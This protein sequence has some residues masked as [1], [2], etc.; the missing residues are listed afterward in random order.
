VAQL[1]TLGGMNTTAMNDSR[2]RILRILFVIFET[3]FVGSYI[4]IWR[5]GWHSEMTPSV[6]VLA[7]GQ[8]IS[9]LALLI[10]SFWLWRV[11]WIL[12]FIGWFSVI[13]YFI[14][15]LMPK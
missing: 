10:L 14:L 7:F 3:W 4:V 12:A 13:A 2:Q 11:A 5:L 15:W 1:S 6:A 9:I 8:W